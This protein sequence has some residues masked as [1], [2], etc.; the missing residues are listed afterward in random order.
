MSHIV[1]IQTEVRD[2][3]AVAAACTRLKLPAPKQGVFRLF[4]SE[5]A[6]L[7]VELPAWRYPVVC[8]LETGQL[9]LDNFNGRWGARRY[10]DA[11]LQAYAVERTRLEAHRK[12]YSV[13]E[14]GLADGSIKLS[15]QVGGAA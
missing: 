2:A 8:K 11:F 12:G 6:G 3:T 10:L 14:Q 5:A 1:I 9:Q 7:G 15:V 4:S 13:T